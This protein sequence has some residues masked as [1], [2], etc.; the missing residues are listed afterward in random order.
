MELLPALLFLQSTLAAT[1]RMA[2]P[3]LYAAIGEVFSER[4]GVLNIGLEGIMLIG[5]F[6]AYSTAF[7]TG[8]LVLGLIA[9]VLS[10][11]VCGLVFALFTVTIKANQIVVGAAFNMI[12]MGITGFL[13]RA[14]YAESGKVLSLKTFLPLD[15]PFLSSIPFLGEVLFRHNI[16][17]YATLLLV[18]AASF[19]LYKTAFGLSIRAVGEHPKAADTAGINVHRTRYISVLIGTSLA[20]IGGAFLVLAYADQFVEGIVTGRGFIALAVVVF[21]GWSPWGAMGTSLLFGVF[22]ALQLRIQAMP[23]VL[24]PYQFLQALP[25]LATLLVLVGLTKRRV[26]A[27]KAL[28]IPY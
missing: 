17:V 21:G 16:M 24:I 28:G 27:P 19:V 18:P 14:F 7:E 8:N 10:G 3:I 20:A 12:G 4:A 5:A 25:Y 6:A 26:R 13:Y 11:L 2:T 9:A 23:N 1:W 22:Y 15:L